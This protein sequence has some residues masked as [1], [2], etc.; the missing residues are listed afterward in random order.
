MFRS[1]AATLPV[2]F[3]ASNVA[4][5]QFDMQDIIES[6]FSNGILKIDVSSNTP[7][8]VGEK[9]ICS[10]QGTG[11]LLSSSHVA[12]ATHVLQLDPRCGSPVIIVR[13]RAHHVNQI[14]TLVSSRDDISILKTHSKLPGTMCSLGLAQNDIYN[15]Q[16][17]KFGIP[18]LNE[19]PAVLPV[20][21]GKKDSEFSPLVTL[22]GSATEFGESGSPI[23]HKFN[24]AGVLSVKFVKYSGY[25]LMVT[26]SILQSLIRSS[27]LQA[28]GRL[29]NPVELHKA[30][31]NGTEAI[32]RP[33]SDLSPEAR[34]I[35]FDE[36]AKAMQPALE[37][38]PG[39]SASEDLNEV[40]LSVGGVV[41]KQICGRGILG[42][43]DV[44]CRDVT[45]FVPS[46]QATDKVASEVAVR[47]REGLWQ[48]A[49]EPIKSVNRK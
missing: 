29:C 32:L 4:V 22:T 11:F 35:V 48:N 15:A 21:I 26:S 8:I 37:R 36:I 9:N 34:D 33:R 7:V 18:A 14:A 6:T 31:A 41:Q 42:F 19:D 49:F 13:S 38:Y 3:V 2:V 24:V 27:N 28:D 10:S 17:I 1:F 12:T 44:G 40:R 43:R 20:R 39:A 47:A 5:A 16:G 30:Q 46:A 23:V 45:L 25:S